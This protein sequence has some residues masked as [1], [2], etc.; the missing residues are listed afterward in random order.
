MSHNV[1]T[2]PIERHIDTDCWLLGSA[3]KVVYFNC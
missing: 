1:E 2:E 3:Y